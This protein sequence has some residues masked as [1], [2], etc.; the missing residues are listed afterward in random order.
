MKN[1]KKNNILNTWEITVLLLMLTILFSKCIQKYNSYLLD[2]VLHN[3][4]TLKIPKPVYSKELTNCSSKVVK[5]FCF[6]Y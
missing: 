6:Q 1:V 2:I 3:I 4:W 5:R